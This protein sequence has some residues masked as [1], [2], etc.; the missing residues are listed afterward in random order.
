MDGRV[1]MSSFRGGRK[2]SMPGVRSFG[3]KRVH[4]TC[5]VPNGFRGT[6]SFPRTRWRPDAREQDSANA[7]SFVNGTIEGFV[8]DLSLDEQLGELAPLGPTL[9][10]HARQ[11]CK[12]SSGTMSALETA[13]V[14]GE[15]LSV[16]SLSRR[17]RA[18]CI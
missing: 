5:A 14:A 7:G 11:V 13:S 9:E 17:M 8:R 2:P 18:V 3:Q 16:Y 10:R 15:W 1:M 4:R 6:Q 12:I